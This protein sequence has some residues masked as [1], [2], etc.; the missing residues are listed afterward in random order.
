M[1]RWIGLIGS[2]ALLVLG[3]GLLAF[4]VSAEMINL[5][6]GQEFRRI[7]VIDSMIG[8]WK[9]E[10]L[11]QIADRMK[12]SETTLESLRSRV[13][14]V[15]DQISDRQDSAQV[16]VVSL[17]EHRVRLRRQGK[18]V[19]DAICAT[20]KNTSLRQGGRTVVF[21]T[22]VG[23]FRVLSKE[24]DPKWIPPDW[25]YV[26]LAN[27]KGMR[28]VHLRR[29]ET[30][31]SGDRSLTVRG[32]NVVEIENGVARALPAGQEIYAGDAVVI[33][34]VGTRQREY[35]DVLGIRRLNLGD[36]YAL[37]GTEAVSSLGQNASHGCIR[38]R[39]SDIRQL[40]DMVNVGDEVI[41]Y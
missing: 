39:N 9:Q 13:G 12:R 24:E 21:R 4:G 22:P 5:R 35:P 2:W 15:S 30:L 33:P 27:R 36:G 23:K 34:P 11:E 28:V 18:T 16:V 6:D 10:R 38:M 3:L 41:I 19:F 17:A 14:S 40:Y 29:G 37:H 31:G 20:G 8:Q 1:K 26:E 7:E 32:D 25:H